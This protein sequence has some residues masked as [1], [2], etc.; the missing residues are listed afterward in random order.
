MTDPLVA[1]LEQA[2]EELRSRSNELAELAGSLAHEIKTPL[3]V[4]RLNVEL[5]AEDLA[6]LDHPEARRLMQRVAVVQRQCSRLE[7]LLND[8][9]RLTRLSHLELTAG[10]LNH[11]LGQVLDFFEAEAKRRGV[12]I[13][14]YLETDL[15]AVMMDKP[16][17]QAALTNMVKNAM[18]SMPA[19]G[20][21]V[22]RTRMTRTGVAVDLIDTGIG[23]DSSTLLKM[24]E[25]FYTTKE[26]GSGL[27]LPMAKKVIEAHGGVIHVQSEVERGTQFTLEFPTPKRL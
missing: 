7:G 10:S 19:G 6:E 21:L 12:E 9:L 14:R 25:P 17:L 18:E 3:S 22:V 26:G 11:L 13:L 4:I 23:I 8:F 2:N 15:P 1:R 16:T 5:I 27:G 24:F 20:E